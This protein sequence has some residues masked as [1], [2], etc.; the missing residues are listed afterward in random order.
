MKKI[1]LVFMV[2]LCFLLTNVQTDS[3][4]IYLDN[5]FGTLNKSQVPSGYLAGSGSFTLVGI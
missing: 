5:L 2:V 3:L 1:L 4:R